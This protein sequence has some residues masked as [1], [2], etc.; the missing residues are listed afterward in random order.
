MRFA[1]LRASLRSRGPGG[2]LATIGI[3]GL[4]LTWL[5]PFAWMVAASLKPTAQIY[6]TGLFSGDFS[7]DNFR[8]LFATADKLDRPFVQA[9]AISALVT[10]SVT[11]SV[12]ISSAF[13]AY[14]LARLTEVREGAAAGAAARLQPANAHS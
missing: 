7:F 3:Y 14:A 4:A 12:L 2:W 8:F 13:I 1:Q 5:Y 10:A 6:S 11:V 9:M